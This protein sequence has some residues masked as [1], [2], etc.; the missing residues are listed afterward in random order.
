MPHYPLAK[1]LGWLQRFLYHVEAGELTTPQPVIELAN[2]PFRWRWFRATYTTV[3]SGNV[4]TIV[5][6]VDQTRQRLACWGEIV[7]AAVIPASDNVKLTLVVDGLAFQCMACDNGIVAGN[8]WPLIRQ[9]F[10]IGTFDL[11]FK[12]CDPVVV[13]PGAT[14]QVDHTN[15]GAG[16]VDVTVRILAVDVPKD[17]PFPN[18]Y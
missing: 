13:P 4:S 3:V 2:E 18:V 7:S 10:W 14:L 17:Q 9:V 12:G 8:S 15:A 6:P 16:A 11:G 1:Y 5:I